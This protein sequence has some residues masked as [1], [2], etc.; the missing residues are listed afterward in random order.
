M[1]CVRLPSGDRWH[2]VV[3]DGLVLGAPRTRCGVQG[4][5]VEIRDVALND[6]ERRICQNCDADLR[7]QGCLTKPAR[8]KRKANREFYRTRKK[9]RF[10]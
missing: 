5:P 2:H 10:E 7:R 6:P 1:I 3:T 4:G 8:P 9:E